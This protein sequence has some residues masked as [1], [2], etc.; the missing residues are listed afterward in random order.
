M[1]HLKLPFIIFLISFS[2]YSYSFETKKFG[3]GT[4]L[5][6]KIYEERNPVDN[7]FFMDQSGFMLGLVANGDNFTE[8]SYLGYSARLGVGL[9]DYTSEGTGTMQDIPDYHA[10][11]NLY[12]GIPF[13]KFDLRI[14]P[15][16]GFGYRYLLNASGQK[17][18][19]NGYSGYD[20]ESRYFYMPLGLNFETKPNA[21]GSHWEFRGEYLHFLFGQ[22]KSYLSQVSSSYPDITN[23]QEQ[24]SGI[25][26][27]AKYHFDKQFALEGYMDYWD[28]AD[29]KVDI[30][31]NFMEP[32]NS[33]SETGI[34]FIWSY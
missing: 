5:S 20:R 15:F 2:S 28:I 4:Y 29:S 13:Q 7:T 16:A 19:S 27:T 22:Q 1:K 11:L 6:T 18:S 32:R 30:T 21:K 9:V 10:E 24:G 14:T 34:R 31:G 8:S 33:T 25:K 17:L 26:V 3:I 12:A 23:D